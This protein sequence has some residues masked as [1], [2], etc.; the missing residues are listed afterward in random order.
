MK[1]NERKRVR[2]E[3]NK[4]TE[5]DMNEGRKAVRV[6]ETGKEISK[7]KINDEIIQ[8]ERM[9]WKKRDTLKENYGISKWKERM[10][11]TNT[12]N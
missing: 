3:T 1:S 12:N 6:K 9:K 2:K 4:T 7:K 5:R 8:K 10:N 11:K